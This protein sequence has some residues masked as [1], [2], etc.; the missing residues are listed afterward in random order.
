VL[1][2]I[3]LLIKL[4]TSHTQQFGFAKSAAYTIVCLPCT[5]YTRPVPPYISSYSKFITG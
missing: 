3:A 5:A 2:G 4:L 1:P